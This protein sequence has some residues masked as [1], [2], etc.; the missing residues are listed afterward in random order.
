MFDEDAT[1]FGKDS[2][3]LKSVEGEKF[4]NKASVLKQKERVERQAAAADRERREKELIGVVKS[5]G[6]NKAME[7][8]LGFSINPEVSGSVGDV[9]IQATNLKDFDL[10]EN[11][12]DKEKLSDLQESIFATL[13]GGN[14]C[15]ENQVCYTRKCPGCKE[16]VH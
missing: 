2:S 12:A 4:A 11:L 3:G 5:G 6:A 8:G 7:K 10:L 14:I 9:R 1:I 16:W 13:V 15:L